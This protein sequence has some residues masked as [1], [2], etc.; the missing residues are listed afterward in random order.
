MSQAALSQTAATLILL[1]G[2]QLTRAFA[3]AIAGSYV[4]LHSSPATIQ[5]VMGVP[6]SRLRPYAD[7]LS[8][9]SNTSELLIALLAAADTATRLIAEQPLVEIAWTY[10]GGSV[11]ARTTA[12]VAKEVIDSSQRTLLVVGYSVTV[13]EDMI[14][15]A[16]Q[17]IQAVAQAAERGVVVTAVLHRNVNRDAFLAAWRPSTPPPSI[18]SWPQAD[19]DK[20]SVHAKILIADRRSA[21]V[22]SANLTY[23]GFERNIEMGLHV[24]GQPA[25][26]IHDR[27]HG[28]IADGT[29]TS[30]TD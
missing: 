18:F 5:K 25:A 30:W 6:Q 4:D 1:E 16:A 24:T 21:L 19:D 20:A 23:H 2:E 28:L 27:F 13:D 10:P 12:A 11:G 15:M 17:S 9:A 14:G 7:A 8:A 22:T 29:L 26:E 3:E